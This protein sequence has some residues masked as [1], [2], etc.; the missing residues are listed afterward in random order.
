MLQYPL[1][2]GEGGVPM[3]GMG[4]E[5]YDYKKGRRPHP[6]LLLRGEGINNY[7]FPVNPKNAFEK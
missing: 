6:S 7:F 4:R 2:L 5:F 1:L 3:R